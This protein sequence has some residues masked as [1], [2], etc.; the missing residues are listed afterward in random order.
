MTARPTE[1]A[2]IAELFA[3]LA[4]GAPG[5]L[6][7][8]DDA[9][10]LSVAVDHELVVTNDCMIAG[11]HFRQADTAATAAH[12][13]LRSNLS[14]LAAMGATPVGYTMALA[15]AQDW[16]FDWVEEFA[17]TLGADQSAFGITLIG[18]DTVSSPGPTMISMTALGNVPKGRALRR[19]GAQAGDD[20]WVTGTIGDA[21][22]GLRL[23]Q[24]EISV[25]DTEVGDF[26]T[27][28]Y[29]RPTPRLG[30][31]QSLRGMATAAIDV[32]DGLLADLGHICRG[33][34]LAAKITAG[35]IPLSTPAQCVLA[36]G[37]STPNEL[38]SGGDDYELVFTAPST[39][40]EYIASCSVKSKTPASRI[41]QMIEGTGIE[42]LDAD[43]NKISIESTG[44][45][46]F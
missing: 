34:A 18:G 12:R 42:V 3:P 26:L 45:R 21:A 46:H 5:A 30:L 28:R 6:G 2:L 10:L 29:M 35:E 25:S 38:W 19:S 20:I 43:G 16:Q 7:L 9:A 31:G 13:T 15:L 17:E 40:A 1:F 24:G 44:Y 8:Q 22:L 23:L 41:G 11:I 27:R 14:D 37:T 36:T 33:S 4:A 32:S 39:A